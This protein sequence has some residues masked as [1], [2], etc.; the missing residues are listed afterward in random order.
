MGVLRLVVVGDVQGVARAVLAEN[1]FEGNE[2]L[3]RLAVAAFRRRVLPVL[4]QNFASEIQR[5]LSRRGITA[6]VEARGFKVRR[7]ENGQLYEIQSFA[8]PGLERVRLNAL[9]NMWNERIEQTF[10]AFLQDNAPWM[11]AAINQP[12]TAEDWIA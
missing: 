5:A 3:Y 2:A 10:A 9:E 11:L 7:D 6:L 1:G 8:S 12:R 4:E